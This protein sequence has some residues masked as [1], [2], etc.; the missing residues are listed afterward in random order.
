MEK[1]EIE[2]SVAGASLTGN[3]G[4]AASACIELLLSKGEVVHA[5][6]RSARVYKV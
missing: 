2:E 4:V 5:H 3:M 1:T 6:N